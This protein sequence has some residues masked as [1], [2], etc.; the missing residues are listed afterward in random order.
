VTL[1]VPIGDRE[2]GDIRV[3]SGKRQKRQHWKLEAAA[4]A[5]TKRKPRP[6]E[7]KGRGRGLNL[8]KAGFMASDHHC[9]EL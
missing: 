5:S 8:K 4:A 7:A 9:A 2:R 6:R 1:D 3:K